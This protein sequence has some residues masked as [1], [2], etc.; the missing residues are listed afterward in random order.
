MNRITE[1]A[2]KMLESLP[3]ELQKSILERLRELI[4]EARDEARW[5]ELFEQKKEGLITT[6]QK[7]RREIAEGKATEMDI[8]KL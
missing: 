1:T 6:A 3:E 7:A 2:I 8:K 5:D 4:E